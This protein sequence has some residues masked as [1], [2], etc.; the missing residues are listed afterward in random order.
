MQTMV[1]RS[2][3][4]KLRLRNFDA[5]NERIETGA[6]VTRRKGLSGVETEQGVCYQWKATGQCSRADVC[7]FQHDRDDRGKPTPKTAPP[8]EPP[9]E[10]SASRKKNLRGWSRVFWKPVNLQDCVWENLYRTIM[11]TILQEKETI[12]YSITI[13]FTNLFLCP[14]P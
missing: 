8:S 10:R 12:H 6:V 13:W 3:D 5:R 1:K 14:K 4:Q 9:T 7:S 2:M 11:K